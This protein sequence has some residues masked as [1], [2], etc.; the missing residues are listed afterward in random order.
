MFTTAQKN[1]LIKITELLLPLDTVWALTGSAAFSLQGLDMEVHDI[2][3]QTDERGAYLI[4]QT[5]SQFIV[6]PVRFS[7]TTQIRSHFGQFMLDGVP[8][9]LM[10][11]VQKFHEGCWEDSIN[12]L[13]LIRYIPLGRHNVPV[14]DLRYECEAYRKMGRLHKA[15]LIEDFLR[16]RA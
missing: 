5:L 10:G 11:G 1:V 9:D 12:L 2:D 3:I 4:E 14:L 6:K 16:S 15:R 13:P 7:A 8:L